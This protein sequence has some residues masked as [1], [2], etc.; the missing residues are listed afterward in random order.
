M[1]KHFLPRPCLDGSHITSRKILNLKLLDAEST[2]IGLKK[3]IC[4]QLHDFLSQ[5]SGSPLSLFW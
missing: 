5:P 1:W 2:F 3:V 4:D